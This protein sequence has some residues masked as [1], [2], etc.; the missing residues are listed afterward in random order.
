MKNHWIKAI[1]IVLLLLISAVWLTQPDTLP[2]GSDDDQSLVLYDRNGQ[3][4]RDIPHKNG[5]RKTFISLQNIPLSLKRAFV[6]AEDR[7]FYEHSGV[8]LY[9]L[10]RA[11]WQNMKHGR[12]ISGASTISMQVARLAYDLD[13]GYFD[14]LRQLVMAW[15]IEANYNKGQILEYYLNN[16]PFGGIAYGVAEACQVYFASSC[17]RLSQAQASTLAIMVRAPTELFADPDALQL[18]RN[19]LLES[20][21][22]RGWLNKENLTAA[23]NESLGMQK[24]MSSF[25]APHFTEWV[26]QQAG[27]Q[28]AGRLTTTLDATLQRDVQAMAKSH[29]AKL[30]NKNVNTGAVIVVE[31]AT[32]EILSYVGSPDYYDNKNKGKLDYVQTRRQ[33]GSVVKPF[34]YVLALQNGYTLSSVLP[35]LPRVFTTEAGAYR[36]KNYSGRFTGPRRL[37]EA[38]ANSLN[39][40]ALHTAIEL[41][42]ERLLHLYHKVGMV[43]L[44]QNGTY[45]GPG[46]TLGNGEVSLLEL[47]QAFVTLARNGEMI[48]LSALKQNELNSRSRKLIPERVAYLISDVLRDPLSREDEFGR[49]NPLN[50]NFPVSAKT[51][52]SSDFRD[53]WVIGYSGELTVAVWVGNDMSK[54]MKQVSGITGAGPLFHD[55][56]VRAMQ[57]R[58]QH[59]LQKPDGLVSR[60]I[61]PLS[62]KL[63]GPHCESTITELFRH[64]HEPNELCDYHREVTVKQCR[65]QTR[66]LKYV[67][68]PAQY[69]DWQDRSSLPS[70][71][72]M[73]KEYCDG[74]G[75]IDRSETE[76]PEQI[77][78]TQILEPVN[79]SYYALDPNIPQSHQQM[80]IHL[81]L[82]IGT[83]KV[84]ILLNNKLTTLKQLGPDVWLWPLQSG[85]HQL[86]ARIELNN[87]VTMDTDDVEFK[88]F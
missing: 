59:W 9:A 41:G 84:D 30:H 64:E 16:V 36:P 2:I 61:C 23:L 1:V 75:V 13:R 19:Q 70:L 10:A 62:G 8:D 44:T 52:T 58:S 48:E 51:G 88:V 42:T 4:L 63:A 49:F 32:G 66:Q 22:D 86:H 85:S 55:V 81:L 25:H 39:I 47:A 40:P 46:L 17:E 83:K 60:K 37:R 21:V 26:Y 77:L 69:S 33:P 14:K 73:R 7:R 20:Y 68:L 54:P 18:R 56:M 82:P 38:L 76:F 80:A 5:H 27:E 35:D 24:N 3:L 29:V 11:F 43:N 15:K 67:Q 65:S 74:Q 31:N 72:Y 87:G 12:T 53:N 28:T 57:G 34:T 79:G 45:Y 78:H 50:F 71:S 6:L